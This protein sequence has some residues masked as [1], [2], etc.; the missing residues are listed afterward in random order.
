MVVGNNNTS[1]RMSVLLFSSA[2]SNLCHSRIHSL[3]LE[4]VINTEKQHKTAK[5]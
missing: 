5:F 4:I 2:I 3:L 1:V